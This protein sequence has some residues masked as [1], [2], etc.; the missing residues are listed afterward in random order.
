MEVITADPVE[1][2]TVD[3][4]WCDNFARYEGGIWSYDH[5]FDERRRH[6]VLD[7]TAAHRQTQYARL[8]RKKG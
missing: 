4:R 7:T 3:C 1:G 5:S 6:E 2:Q 8:L